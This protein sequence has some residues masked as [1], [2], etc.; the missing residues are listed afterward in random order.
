MDEFI[1]TLTSGVF[2]FLAYLLGHRYAL[3]F[4]NGPFFLVIV[5]MNSLDLMI[6][7]LVIS[8]YTS[9]VVW[10]VFNKPLDETLVPV[11]GKVL[12]HCAWFG[13]S[14][15]LYQKKIFFKSLGKLFVVG[16]RF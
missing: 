13:C 7:A 8:R 15:F 4:Q 14:L 16:C 10:K 9:S 6:Y 5:G 11:Y 3:K 1:H 12:V 2:L